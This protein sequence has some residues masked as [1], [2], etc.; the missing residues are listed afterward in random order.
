MNPALEILS[1]TSKFSFYKHYRDIGLMELIVSLFRSL[2]PSH[3]FLVSNSKQM[4]LI[5]TLN[6]IML[7]YLYA[8]MIFWCLQCKFKQVLNMKLILTPSHERTHNTWYYIIYLNIALLH[9]S[10][11][12]CLKQTTNSLPV[13]RDKKNHT[14]MHVNSA[15][16]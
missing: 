14:R 5:C 8:M 10:I 16:K 12:T 13:Q 2:Y 4:C 15:T 9:A 3:F 7:K 6:Y 1:L 11:Y